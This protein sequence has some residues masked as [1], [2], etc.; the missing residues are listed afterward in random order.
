MEKVTVR[1]LKFND[2]HESL[3]KGSRKQCFEYKLHAW[4]MRCERDMRDWKCGIIK[5]EDYY[6]YVTEL[7]TLCFLIKYADQYQ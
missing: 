6:I 3:S 1:G 5:L 4:K 7:E 2:S